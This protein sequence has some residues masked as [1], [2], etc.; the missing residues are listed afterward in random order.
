M[1]RNV[2]VFPSITSTFDVLKNTEKREHLLRLPNIFWTT[3]IMV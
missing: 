1:P 3:F 2:N